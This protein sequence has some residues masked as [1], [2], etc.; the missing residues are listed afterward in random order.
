MNVGHETCRDEPRQL[1]YTVLGVAWIILCPR[2]L[3]PQNT[4]GPI[5]GDRNRN[6]MLDANPHIERIAETTSMTILH[7][8]FHAIYPTISK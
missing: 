2:L 3:P 5:Q 6:H 4:L 7:E 8:L 1:G